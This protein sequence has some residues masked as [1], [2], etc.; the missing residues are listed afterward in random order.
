MEI[1]P[2]RRSNIPEQIVEWFFNS[3]RKGELVPGQ[4]L[5]TEK[6]LAERFNVGRTSVREAMKILE[7]LGM[8]ERTNE[9]TRI[10]QTGNDVL[11]TCVESA[12]TYAR[13]A[14]GTH[15]VGDL[16][17]VRKILEGAIAELAARRRTPEDLAELRELLRAKEKAIAGAGLDCVLQTAVDFHQ[18]LAEASGNSLLA[19][20]VKVLRVIIG[21][22]DEEA[23][24]AGFLDPQVS[25]AHH[26]RIFKAVEE[27][28]P[29]AARA[30][31]EAHIEQVGKM[32]FEY[33]G[34]GYGAGKGT[35]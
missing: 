26:R 35:G 3:F 16:L 22:T 28:D 17:E 15:E 32:L 12:M 8:V 24:R 27:G 34:S 23:V 30:A 7:T 5:P 9:G 13:H 6:E 21:E 10:R 25:L 1:T 20:L 18:T 33:L 31:M 2:I 4:R 29:A 19:A 14:I 11:S